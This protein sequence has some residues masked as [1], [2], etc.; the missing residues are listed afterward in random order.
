MIGRKLDYLFG[1]ATGRAHNIERSTDM[2]RQ[3]KRIGLPDTPANRQLMTKH[4]QDVLNDSKNIIGKG[5]NGTDI[6]ES[7]LMG[8]NGGLK[9]TSNW[10]GD[11]LETFILGG[12]GNR[13]TK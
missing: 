3:M 2:L 8:P 12:V 10:D 11:T 7:L 6:R 13:F 9:V 4:F 5:R 1:K